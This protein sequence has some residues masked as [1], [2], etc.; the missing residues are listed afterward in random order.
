MM[1]TLHSHHTFYRSMIFIQTEGLWLPLRVVMITIY[2][3]NSCCQTWIEYLPTQASYLPI[4]KQAFDHMSIVG[5]SNRYIIMQV[6][7]PIGL[8]EHNTKCEGKGR[9]HSPSQWCCQVCTGNG[10]M[11]MGDGEQEWEE[12]GNGNK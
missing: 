4:D 1:N 9:G 6:C 8:L 3:H 10:R 12:S 5:V 7:R 11:G 2:C